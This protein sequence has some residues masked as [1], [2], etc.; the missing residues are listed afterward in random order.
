[1]RKSGDSNAFE[2]TQRVKQV[3]ETHAQKNLY[4]TFLPQGKVGKLIKIRKLKITIKIKWTKQINK[5]EETEEFY[6]YWQ[7]TKETIEFPKYKKVKKNNKNNDKITK[8]WN[9]KIRIAA[10]K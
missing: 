10:K 5:I 8:N 6:E 7:K 4:S 1:M 9:E 3:Y 2:F